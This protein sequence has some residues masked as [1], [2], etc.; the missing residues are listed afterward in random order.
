MAFEHTQIRDAAAKYIEAGFKLCQPEPASKGPEYRNW[1]HNPRTIENINESSGLGLLHVQSGTCAIDL[2]ALFEASEWL[3]SKHI[4]VSALLQA[5]DAVQITSGRPNRAKLLYRLPDGVASLPTHKLK[6][7]GGETMIE[8]RCASQDGTSLQDV[9]PPSIHPDT[10]K[11]YEWAGAGDFHNLPLLPDAFLGLWQNH[12]ASDGPAKA[13]TAT[14]DGSIVEGGRNDALFKKAGDMAY[15]KLPEAAINAA[16]QEVNRQQCKPP[17]PVHEVSTIAKSATK[18]SQGAK[19]A[20]VDLSGFLGKVNPETGEIVFSLDQF[21]LN[22]QSQEMRKK[23]LADQHV[24]GRLALRGQA[25]VF[26]A[27]RNGG[28]TLLMNYLLIDGI[29]NGGVDGSKVYYVN[30]DDTHKGLIEKTELA[31]KHGFKVLSD[32]YNGFKNDMLPDILDQISASGNASGQIV[33]LDTLKKFTDLMD[34]KKSTDFMQRLRAFVLQGGTVIMLAHVNKHRD[35][36]GKLVFS[37][38]TDVVDDADC[39]YIMEK[40][41][42]NGVTIVT[43]EN[44]KARGDVADKAVYSFE[45]GGTYADLLASVQPVSEDDLKRAKQGERVESLLSANSKII[46]AA[47]PAIEAGITKRTEL[48]N[49]VHGQTGISKRKVIE[50]IDA[51]TGTNWLAGHRWELVKGDKNTKL[52]RALAIF[53]TTKATAKTE[54]EVEI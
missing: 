45:R 49:E 36:N 20:Q 21:A 3:S 12:A 46:A 47:L 14:A 42:R 38:T 2:D 5:D 18:T 16:L 19:N 34:K 35:E 29:R 31:E 25:T 40:V 52:Y 43:F 44:F 13:P 24:L 27:E 22:G 1:Q 15:L 17:L 30:S 54:E 23:M 51:H 6:A 4:D 50:A 8:F 33:I 9:L 28:K 7:P 37:G 41:E 39:A 11:P 10:G 32:G 53:G 48:I 26:F